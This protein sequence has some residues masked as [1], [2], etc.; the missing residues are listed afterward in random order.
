MSSIQCAE[1]VISSRRNLQL[2]P[3]IPRFEEAQCEFFHRTPK[4]YCSG[5]KESNHDTSIEQESLDS[6][7]H[8]INYTLEAEKREIN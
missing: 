8:L 5:C 4:H 3:S 6:E 7:E 2:E 1:D